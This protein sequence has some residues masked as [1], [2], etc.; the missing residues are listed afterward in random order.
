M[1][2]K[3]LSSWKSKISNSHQL[4]GIETSILDNGVG[5]GTRIAWI[6]TGT[7]LRYKVLLDRGMDILEAFYNENSLSWISHAGGI[8]PQPFSNQGIDWLRTFGGGLL[9]TCGLSNAGPPNVDENGSRGLHGNYSNTP[10]ELISIRQPDIFSEELNFEIIGKI[11]ETTTFGP[12]LELTRTIS[13][14]LGS[15]EIHIKDLVVNRGNSP[16]PHM[17]LYHINCGWPLI[18]EGTRIV[19]KGEKIPK[20]SDSNNTAF[21]KTHGFTRCAAPMEA[22][23]GFGEDVA[24][25]KPIADQDDLVTCGYANDIL[26]LALKI[27]FQRSQMPWLINWQHWGKNEYVTALEPATHPPIGQANANEEG[28]LILLEPGESREYQLKLAVLSAEE[29][30]NFKL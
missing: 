17:L 22:H 25:I 5:K 19:W 30:L 28:S 16:A 12:S 13:G 18:D 24:F 26:G 7:G 14:S 8:T 21:N 2:P 27:E 29:V 1:N 11:R 4:G 23:S 6:N 3:E 15:A 20:A 9:T 10:A